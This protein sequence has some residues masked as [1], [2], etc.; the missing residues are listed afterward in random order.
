VRPAATVVKI[1][2]HAFVKC[3]LQPAYVAAGMP[4]AASKMIV[5]DEN[6]LAVVVIDD[7]ARARRW[8][9]TAGNVNVAESPLTEY[10]GTFGVGVVRSYVPC[11][12]ESVPLIEASI[13]ELRDA[14]V[15]TVI[16]G[17]VEMP[18]WSSV[19]SMSLVPATL[20][21]SS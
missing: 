17:S 20:A 11:S 13:G 1:V 5:P 8:P 10:V 16:A 21:V 12:I 9:L 6:V 14:S 3:E 2:R 7:V 19:S 18:S 15:V 4:P